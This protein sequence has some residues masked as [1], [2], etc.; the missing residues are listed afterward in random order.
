MKK[1]FMILSLALILCFI[2]GCQ[3]KEAMAELEEFRAQAELEE[4][5][6]ALVLKW[7]EELDKANIEACIEMFSQDF[8]WYA[9]SNSPTPMSKKKSQKYM[10]EGS[11]SFPK[12]IHKIEEIMTSGDKVIARTVDYLTHEGEYLGIPATGKEIEFSVIVIFQVKD[13]K[14]VELRE[15]VDLLGAIQQI[16]IELKPKGRE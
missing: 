12:M 16:G 14:I 6:K 13:G 8:L 7:Y 15:E 11:K 3:D 4:Q 9:P 2:V 10:I 1:L 5:N